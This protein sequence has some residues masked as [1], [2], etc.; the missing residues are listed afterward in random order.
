[1][2][3]VIIVLRMIILETFVLNE[4]PV[5][6]LLLRLILIMKIF[7][8]TKEGPEAVVIGGG[9][10]MNPKLVERKLTAVNQCLVN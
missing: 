9:L 4:E 3:L 1:M 2:F 7:K 5:T 8:S 10:F 6:Y